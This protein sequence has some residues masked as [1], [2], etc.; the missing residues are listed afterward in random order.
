MQKEEALLRV[1]GGFPA[2]YRQYP[3]IMRTRGKFLHVIARSEATWQSV[4][5]AAVHNEEQY[6]RRI[7]KSV[8]EFAQTAA[9]L[10]GSFAGTRIATGVRTGSQ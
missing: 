5:P 10:P 1:Q 3:G 4:L 7:R 2:V 8:Y 9:T 6:L